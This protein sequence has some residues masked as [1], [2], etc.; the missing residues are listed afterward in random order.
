MDLLEIILCGI[1]YVILALIAT[2]V[3]YRKIAYVEGAESQDFS[4]AFTLSQP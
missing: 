3:S 2:R 4:P 1:I